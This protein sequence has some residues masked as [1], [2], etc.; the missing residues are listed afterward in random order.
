MRCDVICMWLG[1]CLLY[2]AR[3]KYLLKNDLQNIAEQTVLNSGC[4]IHGY[5]ACFWWALAE[6]GR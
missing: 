3:R 1:V 5:D 6:I 4:S 2:K